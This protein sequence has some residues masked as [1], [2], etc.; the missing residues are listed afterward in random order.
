MSSARAAAKLATLVFETFKSH[1]P[2]AVEAIEIEKQ[3]PCLIE[4]SKVL[5]PFTE[6]MI[7]PESAA[8]ALRLQPDGQLNL[9]LLFPTGTDPKAVSDVPSIAAMK[10]MEYLATGFGEGEDKPPEGA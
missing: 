6:R 5:E 4:L 1:Y 3:M 9:A 10:A 2:G 7:A 8:L